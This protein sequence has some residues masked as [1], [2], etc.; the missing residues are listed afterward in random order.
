[1]ISLTKY[2]KNIKNQNTLI[3][4]YSLQKCVSY[5]GLYFLNSIICQ[6]YIFI[7]SDYNNKNNFYLFLLYNYPDIFLFLLTYLLYILLN[8]APSHL[9]YSK[10]FL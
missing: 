7:V 5:L 2:M 3:Y 4:F 1:M 8:I 9:L 10:F 6:K